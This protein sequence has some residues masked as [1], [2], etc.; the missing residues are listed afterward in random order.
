MSR[1]NF[2]VLSYVLLLVPSGVKGFLFDPSKPTIKADLLQLTNTQGD[3]RLN[4]QLH[5][6]DEDGPRLAVTDLVFELHHDD[7]NYDH[8]SLPGAD[9]KHKK[10]SSGHRRLDVIHCGKFINLSG[11]QHVEPQKG[12]WEIC[13]REDKPAGTLICG[14][15]LLRDYTRNE[16]TLPKG[17]VFVSFPVWTKGSLA[18]GQME[19]QKVEMELESYVHERDE[20][21]E[22]FD[23]TNN[24]IMK[25]VYL[26]NAFAACD[27]YNAVD[28]DTV[29]TIPNHHQVFEIQDDL[30]LTMMGLVWT[31]DRNKGEH[32]LLGTAKVAPEIKSSKS[33]LM[34]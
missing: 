23:A 26:H 7:A 9:G 33:R 29:N 18:I 31:K 3:K 22:A 28:H 5:I 15:E 30:L 34:P 20:A 1:R 17:E 13:W 21:L 16:V 8:T 25:A 32:V 27:K 2:L 12:C 24:P 6:G 11:T 10:L 19:K 4:I 14:F